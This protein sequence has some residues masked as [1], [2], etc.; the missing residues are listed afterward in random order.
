MLTGIN[1][2]GVRERDRAIRPGTTAGSRFVLPEAGEARAAAYP[3]A[4]AAADPASLLPLLALQAE[5]DATARNRRTQERTRA[6]LD[7]LTALQSALLAGHTDAGLLARLTSLASAPNEAS[8]PGLAEIADWV[9][10]RANVM[11][12]RLERV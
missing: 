12:A 7:E 3:P 11:L 9:A 5:D 4:V 8:D 6:L 1:G 10:L 2:T